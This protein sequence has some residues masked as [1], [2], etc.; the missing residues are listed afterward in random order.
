M[1]RNCILKIIIIIIIIIIKSVFNDPRSLRLTMANHEKAY[2][3][4]Y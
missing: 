2:F 3:K 4:G 1:D